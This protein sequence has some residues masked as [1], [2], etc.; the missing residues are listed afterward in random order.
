MGFSVRHCL[1]SLSLCLQNSFSILLPNTL[2]LNLSV[3]LPFPSDGPCVHPVLGISYLWDHSVSWPSNS[4]LG[5]CGS[6][7]GNRIKLNHDNA[8]MGVLKCLPEIICTSQIIRPMEWIK[9][10]SSWWLQWKKSLF[11]DGSEPHI[12]W[13]WKQ[14]MN[15][16]FQC[17]LNNICCSFHRYLVLPYIQNNL[18]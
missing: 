14:R 3:H 17:L 9:V 11:Y 4:S 15:K 13:Q 2:T 1:Y 6:Y 16:V 12:S 7:S 10:G 5:P 18:R 8:N